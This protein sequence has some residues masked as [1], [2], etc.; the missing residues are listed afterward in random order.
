MKEKTIKS[1][2]AFR[3][4][5]LRLDLLEVRIRGGR[6]TGREVIRHPGAV[7]VLCRRP[8]RRF[9]L[10]RQFRMPVERVLLEV[11]AGTL[12]RGEKPAAC[13]RREVMEETG[14]RV[15]ALERL[16]RIFPAPGYCDEQITV[17]FAEVE[18]SPSALRP[19]PDEN[20]TTVCLGAR[21]LDD[22]IARGRI[23]DAK[24]VAAWHFYKS[25]RRSA[26]RP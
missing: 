18:D 1:S 19:D 16:G 13:A 21:R 2:C 23:M 10:V 3:G 22:L 15:I 25:S 26:A 24:T 17:Y 5:L 4:R 9:I 14:C 11:A 8:D 20:I 7:A 6:R 12:E